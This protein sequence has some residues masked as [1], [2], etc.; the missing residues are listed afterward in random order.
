MTIENKSDENESPRVLR[1]DFAEK[2]EREQ[3]DDLIQSIDR[4]LIKV[5]SDLD[6]DIIE[7]VVEKPTQNNSE[8]TEIKSSRSSGRKPRNEREE[9]ERSHEN[10]NLSDFFC[11]EL[12]NRA[13]RFGAMLKEHLGGTILI[14]VTPGDERY[15]FDWRGQEP[16]AEATNV[17]EADCTIIISKHNLMQIYSG[18][19][20]PQIGMLTD[21]IKVKGKAGLAI[22]FFNLV[23]PQQSY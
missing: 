6:A 8:E 2:N 19:L 17:K 5:Q 9:Q 4:T 10:E 18:D 7:K 21:K 14:S 23:A 3:K 11:D 12:C 1:E 22:Y 16:R 20:N 13:A 15:L